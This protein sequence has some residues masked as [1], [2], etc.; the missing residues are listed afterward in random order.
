MV[1]ESQ[2]Q[3]IRLHELALLR[4]EP[5]RPLHHV[6]PAHENVVDR[7]R[8]GGLAEAQS[9]AQ[10]H[11]RGGAARW[12][13]VEV[14]AEDER[15]LPR[16]LDRMT[17]GVDDLLGRQLGQTRRRVQVRSSMRMH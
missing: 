16:P 15:I 5:P 11:E 17:R 6:K 14:A 8:P 2:P 1:R 9:L 3:A 4:G 10:L 7:I 12:A 13:Q